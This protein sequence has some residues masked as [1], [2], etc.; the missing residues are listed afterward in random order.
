MTITVPTS[1]VTRFRAGDRLQ[2]TRSLTDY[3]AGTWTLA[4]TLANADGVLTIAASGSGTTYTVDVA[5]A[6]S[7]DY[8]PGWYQM[9]GTLTNSTTD[10]VTLGPWRVE[11]L[12]NLAAAVSGVEWR[13]QARIALDAVRAVIAGRA[14]R[15][16][17]EYSIQ[18]RSLKRTPIADLILLE[19]KLKADVAAEEKA[20]RID[21]GLGGGPKMLVRFI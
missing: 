16:Q 4:Y 5:P 7:A 10:R 3:D 20:E 15:D 1:E 18:G 14:T 9:V 13:S 2:W 8:P 19:N 6:T 17:E 21:S 12:P 11:V